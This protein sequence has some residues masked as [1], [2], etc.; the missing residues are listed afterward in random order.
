MHLVLNH[1]VKQ[2]KSG[3]AAEAVG[4]KAI[5]HGLSP[6]RARRNL[7][8][9]VLSLFSPFERDGT[10]HNELQLAGVRGEDDGKGLSVT[11]SEAPEVEQD[12]A[13]GE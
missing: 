12:D 11:I 5:A 9:T 2:V 13:D 10:L 1:R 7:E 3:F 8:R 4:V 6:E